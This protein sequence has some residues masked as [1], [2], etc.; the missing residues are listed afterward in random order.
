MGFDVVRS[1]ACDQDLDLIF[2]HLVESYLSLGD[3][4]RAAFERA[5]ARVRMIDADMK[6]LGQAPHQGSLRPLIAPGLR[7]VTK[8][9]AIFYFDVDETR[10]EIRILAVFFG[11]QDHQR[12]MLARLGQSKRDS[13]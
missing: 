7:Q 13:D 11:G 2:D 6:A 1:T 12:H 10:R 3:D 8:N 5:A 4:L 9:R